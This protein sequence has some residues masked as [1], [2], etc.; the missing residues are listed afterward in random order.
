M[1]S[2]CL[3]GQTGP[4]KDYPGFGGQ[5]AALSGYNWVTGWPDLEPVGP[6]AT[7]TDSLAPRYV[8]AALAAGLHYRARTGRGVYL[9]VSQVE[10]GTWTLAPWLLAA[11]ARRRHR[12]AR[13]Q[14]VAASRCRTARSRAA[15]RATSAIAGWRSPAGPTTSGRAWPRS[16][17]S[18]N[19]RS[20]RCEARRARVDEV[21]AAV[22]AWTR[23][24][25]RAEVAELLQ[26]EGIEAVPVEDFG[27]VYHDEQLAARG[28]FVHLT[29]PFMGH[30]A[31]R[32]QRRPVVGR[33][34]R[35]RPLGADARSGQRLGARRAPRPESRGAAAPSRRGRG[36]G[37]DASS[38]VDRRAA[39]VH[40]GSSS[41]SRPIC[42]AGSVSI[43]GGASG[44]R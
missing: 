37:L 9:D 17:A 10:A 6:Y 35:L 7:I 3:N 40:A 2:A 39:W 4:H 28:H 30:G 29:H 33:A 5:G 14:P 11:R 34:G 43:S 8:A 21:E 27:D 24:R 13:R 16:S 44:T 42:S 12:H 18:T 22:A 26:A 1:I 20:A 15:T 41:R 38:R 19:R 25:A 36:R 32:A 31:V 23:D